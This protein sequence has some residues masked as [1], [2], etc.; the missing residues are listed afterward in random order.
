VI[1]GES[2]TAFGSAV[3]IVGGGND[4]VNVR[5]VQLPNARPN[6]FVAIIIDAG[7]GNDRVEV[8]NSSARFFTIE[9]G[10]GN[11]TLTFSSNVI[12]EEASLDGGAGFDRLIA[13][14]NTGLLIQFGF[15]RIVLS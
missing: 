1:S 4:R 12:G 3:S 14:G 13:V 9:L 6:D 11:D 10:G 15:E 7:S 8:S 5:N 2:V